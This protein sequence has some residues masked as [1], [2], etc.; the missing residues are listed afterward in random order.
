MQGR[1]RE[2][3]SSVSGGDEGV[4]AIDMHEHRN[5]AVV[6]AIEGRCAVPEW[7]AF[8]EDVTRIFEGVRAEV[9]GGAQ[10]RY[11][12][13][14]ASVPRE[15]FGLAVC[16]VDG[17]MLRLGDADWEFSFQS[18]CGLCARCGHVHSCISVRRWSTVLAC[19]DV[20]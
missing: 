17:Q 15:R 6:R 12:P 10:A 7:P 2:F 16:T 18:G 20:T 13:I 5:N 11:I 8:V 4:A 3:I 9:H 19:V 14:L 1:V